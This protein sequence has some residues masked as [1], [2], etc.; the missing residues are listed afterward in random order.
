M[1]LE[2]LT[3]NAQGALQEASRIAADR[4]HQELDTI[5]L[6]AALISQPESLVPTILKRLGTSS[7]R[8]R[9]D[10][11]TELNRRPTVQGV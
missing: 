6:L 9:P 2:K 1:N 4:H 3:T 7:E 11:D 8:L 10:L 5:H